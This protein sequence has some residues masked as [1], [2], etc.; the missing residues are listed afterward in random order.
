LE[1]LKVHVWDPEGD[2]EDYPSRFYNF[3]LER[4]LFYVNK[5]QHGGTI[6]VIPSR[7]TKMDTHLT[8]LI[9][10]KY[11]CSY[12]YVWDLMVRNLVNNY[13]YY[14][15]HFP[16]WDGK[17][18]LTTDRFQKHSLLRSNRHELEEALG[19]AAQAIAALTSVDGAV[20]MTDRFNVMGF[21]AEVIALS[22]SLPREV[23]IATKSKHRRV[24]IE[25]Y[26]TRHRAAF[27]FCFKLED[28]VAFVASSDG[29]VKAI[30]RVGSDVFLWPD[31]NTDE[32]S[33]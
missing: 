19:D 28:S 23:I 9:N 21:G 3:F 27:R 31:I 1:S 29:G 24:P 33:I 15:L 10:I 6:I 32:F 22:P 18:K 25:S 13:R 4:I 11:Q 30:K 12:S 16:L 2:D 14:A 5:K 26:G 17:L 8:D 7:T 20:V